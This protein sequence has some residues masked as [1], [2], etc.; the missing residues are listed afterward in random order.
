MFLGMR[1]GWVF[2]RFVMMGSD[3]GNAENQVMPDEV[4]YGYF[5]QWMRYAWQL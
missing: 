5:C 1:F 3:V 4:L 2:C